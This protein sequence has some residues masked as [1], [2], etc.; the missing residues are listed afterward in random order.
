MLHALKTDHVF[1]RERPFVKPIKSKENASTILCEVVNVHT[2]S[3]KEY[4]RYIYI[5]IYMYILYSV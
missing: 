2:Y 3:G 1:H 4:V 5:Y